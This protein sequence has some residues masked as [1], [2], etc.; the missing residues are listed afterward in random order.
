MRTGRPP[1]WPPCQRMNANRG[2]EGQD[3]RSN[4]QQTDWADIN[5]SQ[6]TNK[7]NLTTKPV[8]RHPATLH[9]LNK[10]N[11]ITK[12]R[13]LTVPCSPISSG[14][15]IIL[16]AT[17]PVRL[18]L[19]RW[20]G[21]QIQVQSLQPTLIWFGQLCR[22]VGFRS[23][24]RKILNAGF[25]VL[26]CVVGCFQFA[27]EGNKYSTVLYCQYTVLTTLVSLSLNF[28]V[29]VCLCLFVLDFVLSISFVC[30]LALKESFRRSSS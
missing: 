6:V 4:R 20:A 15:D 10:N 9:K 22:G 23:L 8:T 24:C 26:F 2:Q 28:D 18:G 13:G 16:V 12:R 14:H 5:S 17:K 7:L 1:P 3:T 29:S 27:G 11:L 21:D 30:L 25:F 19:A